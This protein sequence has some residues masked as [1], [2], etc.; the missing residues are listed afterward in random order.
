MME[1]RFELFEH[2][3]DQMDAM[4][5]DCGL[6]EGPEGRK[7]F[8]ENAIA[9]FEWAIKQKKLGRI[10]AGVE[11]KKEGYHE[12]ISPALNRVKKSQ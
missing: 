1:I 11:L 6:P 3:V 4:V 8:V 12:L 9:V 2:M 10:V 7:A 5:R